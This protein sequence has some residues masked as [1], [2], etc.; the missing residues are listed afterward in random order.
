R[1]PAH[2]WHR[3]G[4]RDDAGGA[5]PLRRRQRPV[6][7]QRDALRQ[8]TG[9]RGV[10]RRGPAAGPSASAAHPG[11]ALT[12]GGSGYC[13]AHRSGGPT[14][15]GGR[16][17]MSGLQLRMRWE[18]DLESDDHEALAFL[19]AEIYPDYG[20]LFSGRRSWWDAQPEARLIVTD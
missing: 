18:A 7:V 1:G 11:G 20:S 6:D 9:P 10:H 2:R 17:R 3:L 15:A 14:G 19:L 4:P 13:S 8:P 16:S 12:R 5:V